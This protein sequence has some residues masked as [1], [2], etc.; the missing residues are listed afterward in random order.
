MDFTALSHAA[1][2]ISARENSQKN[3]SRSKI[4]K[5]RITQE[6]IAHRTVGYPW[7]QSCAVLGI[8]RPTY[9][10]YLEEAE[11]ELQTQL[12][13][14]RLR[15]AS[16]YYHRMMLLYQKALK[17]A[18]ADGWTPA[19]TQRLESI[20]NAAFDRLAGIRTPVDKPLAETAFAID[21]KT[22]EEALE[23][24]RRNKGIQVEANAV[25]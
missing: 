6:I 20:L 16:D 12:I 5:Q 17:K 13:N 10:R 11:G 18:D 24:A 23:I 2:S 4:E 14:N 19:T 8:S 25:R 1:R 9:Y 15:L 7:H 21:D 22:F 3:K